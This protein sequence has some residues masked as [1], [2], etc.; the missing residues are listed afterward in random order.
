[1]GDRHDQEEVADFVNGEGKRRSWSGNIYDDGVGGKKGKWGEKVLFYCKVDGCEK[2]YS[3]K[4]D[5]QVHIFTHLS[6]HNASLSR[7]HQ[8]SFPGCAKSFTRKHDLERHAAVH[9]EDKIHR[10]DVCLMSFSRSDARKRH[11]DMGKCK[12]PVAMERR[13]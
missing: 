7:P 3:R 1:M 8:C 5:L 13:E 2:S 9:T 10:C 12:G 11:K 6:V 4:V